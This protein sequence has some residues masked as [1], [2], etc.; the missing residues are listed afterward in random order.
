M[1]L[2]A[3]AAEK[4]RIRRPDEI[5][6]HGGIPLQHADKVL[7]CLRNIELTVRSK[8]KHQKQIKIEDETPKE[9]QNPTISQSLCVLKGAVGRYPPEWI[10]LSW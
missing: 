7:L 3:A 8:T 6:R 1:G 4:G 5:L 9:E 10:T 2:A